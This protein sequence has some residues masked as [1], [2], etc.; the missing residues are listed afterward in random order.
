MT[1]ASL[2]KITTAA[3]FPEHFMLENLAV[4]ADGSVLVVASPQRQVWYVP[5]PTEGL[6]VEPILLHTF[7]DGYLDLRLLRGAPQRTRR[8][9]C[10]QRAVGNR[11]APE[12]PKAVVGNNLRDSC[13][14]RIRTQERLP[15]EVHSAQ[16]EITDSPD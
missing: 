7:D 8:R 14:G 16:G 15:Y 2:A 12:L 6:P 9:L 3:N 1:T 11:K 4:C 10:E 5:A 13:L